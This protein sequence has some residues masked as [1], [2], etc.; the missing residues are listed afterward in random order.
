[1]KKIILLFLSLALLLSIGGCAKE[2]EKLPVKVLIVPHFEI[3]EMESDD[4]GEAQMFFEEYLKNGDVY[5]I[6]DGTTL[7]YNPENEVAMYLTGVGK[8]SA[9][10]S[11][12]AVLSDSR[13][14]F[15]K[16][17]L[18]AVGCSGGAI[19]YA[20]LGDVILES[21]VCDYDLGHTADI[22][23][24]RENGTG[25]LWFASSECEE[26]GCQK[27]DPD[28][29]ERAYVLTKDIPLNTTDI[30]RAMLARNFPGEA[31]AMRE[32]SVIK[33]ASVTSDNYWKGQYHHDKAVQVTEYYPCPDPYASTE[34]ED[35]AIAD[36]AARF[37]MLDR[38]LIMRVAVNIDVF[39]DK[40]T[41]EGLWGQ[42]ADFIDEVSENN[43]ETLDIFMPGM[44][45]LFRVGKTI[46]DSILSGEY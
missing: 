41:P 36:V 46:T 32:P 40:M 12:T 44:E 31:W 18:L 10:T 11:T 5:S 33:G 9:A 24:L 29:V 45:N 19:G 22:R 6:A 25:E 7:Y 39:Y 3:G 30:S 37:G 14:D 34:M 15:S 17:Y 26:G 4:P 43:E 20:T 2:A 13:F 42:N 27:F 38:T 35:V 16:S 21:A 1:M 28:T 23:E 8:V